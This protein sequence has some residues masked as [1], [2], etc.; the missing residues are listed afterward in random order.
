M[1]RYCVKS[2]YKMINHLIAEEA[3]EEMDEMA[4]NLLSFRLDHDYTPLT[5]PRQQSPVQ[6][7]ETIDDLAETLSILEGTSLQANVLNNTSKT[8]K[9]VKSTPKTTNKKHVPT[10]SAVTTSRSKVKVLD[11]KHPK[12]LTQKPSRQKTK[13]SDIDTQEFDVDED[14]EEEETGDD[15]GDNDSDFEI[16]DV[17]SKQKTPKR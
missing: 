5:S 17:P 9:V 10:L 12:A 6:D 11:F 13:Q 14:Y 4:R 1:V 7:I 16:D 8:V 3:Y 15:D 2:T